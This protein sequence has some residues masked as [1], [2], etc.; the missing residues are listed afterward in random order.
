[1]EKNLNSDNN[2]EN[3]LKKKVNRTFHSNKQSNGNR[4]RKE[5]VKEGEETQSAKGINKFN[6]IENLFNKARELYAVS[7]SKTIFFIIVIYIYSVNLFVLNLFK[8]IFRLNPNYLGSS[9][10]FRQTRS[11]K[12]RKE[13]DSRHFKIRNIRG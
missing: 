7:V 3:L 5:K 2:K 13:V 11:Q 9:I 6:Q 8:F 4:F 10:R 1:M 12:Q